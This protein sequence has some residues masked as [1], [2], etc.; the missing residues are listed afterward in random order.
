MEQRFTCRTLSNNQPLTS[1]YT[2]DS[3][4]LH[5]TTASVGSITANP[6]P[7]LPDQNGLGQTTVAWTSNVASRAEVHI[8]APDGPGFAGSDP[9]HIFSAYRPL[10]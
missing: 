2:L 1:L 7:F 5:V 3:V 6:N 10:G 9:G 8:N 4:T